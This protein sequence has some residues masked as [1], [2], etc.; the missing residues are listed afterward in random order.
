[1]KELVKENVNGLALSQIHGETVLCCVLSFG[2]HHV[3]LQSGTEEQSQKAFGVWAEGYFK[4]GQNNLNTTRCAPISAC[5]S[6]SS[7]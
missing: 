5:F 3:V 1:M 7:W 2:S 6:F 4:A